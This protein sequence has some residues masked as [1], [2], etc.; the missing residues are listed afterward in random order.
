MKKKIIRRIIALILSVVCAAA[1]I[2]AFPK[3]DTASA[4]SDKDSKVI[5]F[6]GTAGMAAAQPSYDTNA[7]W[8]GSYVYFGNIPG[9][10]Q[11]MKY[12]VL[13]RQTSEYGGST[14]LLDCD[15]TIDFTRF[16]QDGKANTTSAYPTTWRYS[17]L[18]SYL[19]GSDFLTKQGVFTEQERDA[20]YNSNIQSHV[21]QVGDLAGKVSAKTYD[22][23]HD[24]VGL[25]GEKIFV[26]DVE[27]MSNTAYGYNLKKDSYK[28]RNKTNT[29]IGGSSVY[30]LRS[31]NSY[32]YSLGTDSSQYAG[33][34]STTGEITYRLSNSD[35]VA[36][37]PAMNIDLNSVFFCTAI[38]GTS[39]EIGTEYR[40]TINDNN[41]HLDINSSEKPSI[42]NREVNIPF[43]IT[44]SNTYRTDRISVLILDKPFVTEGGNINSSAKI[45]YYDCLNSNTR[46]AASNNGT[47]TLPSGFSTDG[48]GKN[49]YVYVFAEELL[50][51]T[52]ADTDYA[53]FPT[54]VPKP[55]SVQTPLTIV[56]G[57][58]STTVPVGD[59]A[60][61]TV[62]ATGS[63]TLSY[64]WQ[65]QRSDKGE[66]VT[67]YQ[68]GGGKP[69]L[70][71]N[72]T[73]AQHGYLYR[74]KIKDSNG[75]TVYTFA[76]T[77][78]IGPKIRVQPEKIVRVKAGEVAKFSVTVEGKEPLTYRWQARK[79]R[80]SDWVDSSSPSAATSELKI[81]A[82][83][84]H[85]GYEFRCLVY[86]ADNVPVSSNSAY[87]Q[88]TPVFTT[89][90]KAATVPV[91]GTAQFTV[92]AKGAGTLSYQWQAYNP[93]TNKWVD[94]SSPSAKTAKLSLTAQTGHHGFKFRCVVTDK[95]GNSETS[96]E[97]VLKVRPGI[98]TQPKDVTVSVG[99][100][101]KMSI[102][103][104]SV[105][106]LSYQWQV[107]DTATGKWKNSVAAS[108]KTA[109]FTFTAQK[110][111][112][113]KKFRCVLT[114]SN[115]N[116][117][118]SRDTYVTVK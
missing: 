15:R 85:D 6:I 32:N 97:V 116:Q 70:E 105:G 111:H 118:V 52:S 103:A 61:F 92:A 12:R 54:E 23:F 25:N 96:R 55:I 98:V 95:N 93:R 84:G 58:H 108:A 106:S 34:I 53:S 16:D 94:S 31:S 17:D 19:N 66:W 24:F 72:T 86:N 82:Q 104:N 35:N 100:T 113:G 64:S 79:T 56:E 65:C 80:T 2:P 89:Q 13:S 76:V 7:G 33:A 26:L 8:K 28:S 30:W 63:G 47:F 90:P 62:N 5:D 48:W 42:Y 91:G 18:R 57:P 102:K 51:A 67:V 39:G 41:L 14:M 3:I 59:K 115:G 27:D 50:S 87:L 22:T 40:M 21:L 83:T 101:V 109:T 37:S 110:G 71:I 74:C 45:L 112:N 81:T 43:S 1:L 99:G 73:Q 4:A 9:T 107:W 68:N 36:F 49:Y 69:T 11:P 38:V 77:L 60:K 10:S 88:I 29:K 78:Y 46:F 114:D 20:I 75:S 44:G 117:T